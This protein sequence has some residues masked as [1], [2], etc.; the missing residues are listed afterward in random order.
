MISELDF[1]SEHLINAEKDLREVVCMISEKH[2]IECEY[3]ERLKK[4]FNRSFTFAS[5]KYYFNS[6]ISIGLN[7]FKFD[8][9][10]DYELSINFASS[11][12]KNILE[13]ARFFLDD[14]SQNIRKLISDIKKED[15]TQKD[16]TVKLEKVIFQL[17]LNMSNLSYFL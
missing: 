16:I 13:P 1:I 14:Y 17:N 3:A 8:F 9:N 2:E 11:L 15:K 10:L 6:H 5:E 12:R 7:T 4:V